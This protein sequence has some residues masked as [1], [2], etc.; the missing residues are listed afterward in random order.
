MG[1]DTTTQGD[2]PRRRADHHDARRYDDQAHGRGRA[3]TAAAARPA[4]SAGSGGAVRRRQGPHARGPVLWAVCALFALI[5]AVA[6]LLIAVDANAE[7]DLVR[8][9]IERADNV[10]LGFFD[11][12]Q[13]DQGLGQGKR[14]TP[15]GRQDRP[16][17]LRHRRH[18]VA[19]HRQ[20]PRQ[21]RP[22]LSRR[23]GRLERSSPAPAPCPR[24][25]VAHVTRPGGGRV[26][27][28]PVT[29]R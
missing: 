2:T 4:S 8:W 27:R 5:L 26:A 1:D 9:V 21:G 20:V 16:V 14:P 23:T 19:R 3:G 29:R 12:D 18:R 28:S 6:V 15:P 10:D 24:R 25:D 7:N 11:L 13:P 22:P 17:Q